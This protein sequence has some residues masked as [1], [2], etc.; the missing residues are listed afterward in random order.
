[1]IKGTII[2][3]SLRGDASLAGFRFVVSAIGRGHPKLSP[4][5]I[6]PG[7]P[8]VW[9]AIEFE[10]EESRAEELAEALARILDPIGW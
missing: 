2:L 7:I 6:A 10:L 8:S 1:M 9:S 3:E 5:Q 4:E